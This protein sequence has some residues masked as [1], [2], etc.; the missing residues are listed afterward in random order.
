FVYV[1]VAHDGISPEDAD[2]LLYKPLERELRGLDGLK[3]M[4]STAT[5]GHLSI[6]LEF[7]TDV[8]IDQAL[9]DVRQKVDDA[10][11]DL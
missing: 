10:R 11:S 3:E 6:M 9:L 2:S 4:V 7:Y 5:T 1:S 8:D